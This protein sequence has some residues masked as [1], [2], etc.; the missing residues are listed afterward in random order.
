M[1]CSGTHQNAAP[2][3]NHNW[4]WWILFVE[5]L[6]PTHT[7]INSLSKVNGISVP[8]TQPSKT[9]TEYQFK[10]VEEKKVQRK[11][12]S[13][14]SVL[15][16]QIKIKLRTFWSVVLNTVLKLSISS[17]WNWKLSFTVWQFFFPVSTF[18]FL[19]SFLF[20]TACSSV[21]YIS[22]KSLTRAINF[23]GKQISPLMRNEAAV[24]FVL[25]NDWICCQ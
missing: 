19:S 4:L 8:L 10:Q 5:T 14:F 20:F 22:G 3:N 16:H 11:W 1:G 23:A 18:F 9:E 2:T 21:W 25:S 6:F 15:K 17:K 24:K 13:P 7:H 12:K